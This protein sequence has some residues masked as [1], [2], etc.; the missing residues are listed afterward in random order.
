[1]VVR[2]GARAA[3]ALIALVGTAGRVYFDSVPLPADPS[4]P[5]ASEIFYR[6]GHTV[7]A[8]EDREF[9]QH[10]GISIKGVVRAAW[11]NV[12]G[13]SEGAS[14]ITQQYARNAYLS[15]ERTVARKSREIVL[16][17]KLEDRFTKDQILE[18]YLNAIHFGRGAY[19]IAA[20]AQ[21][22]FGVTVDQLSLAQGA[23]LASVI[24]DPWNFDPTVDPAAAH[25]RWGWIV[26][27]MVEL[28][29]A[30]PD[31]TATLHYPT[32]LPAAP[33]DTTTGGVNGLLVDA[34]ERELA[35]IGVTPQQLHTGGLRIV[36][37]VDATAQREALAA[38]EAGREGL[39]P[40]I[41]AA[42]VAID[43]AT[44][45][46][47]AYY[48]GDR[49][50]GYF[51]DATAPR[52]TGATFAPVTLAAGLVRGY[53]VWSTWDGSSPRTFPDRDGAPVVNADAR[54]CRP[55][56]LVDAVADSVNTPVYALSQVIG[57]PGIRGLALQLGVSPSYDGQ[58]SLVDGPGDARPGRTRADIGLGIY[59]VSPADMASVYATFA[60][61][62]ERM[63]RHVVALVAARTSDQPWYVATPSGTR[64]VSPE[65]AADVTAVLSVAARRHAPANDRPVAG[66]T[67]TQQWG[68]T[69]DNQDAW[70]AGYAPQL[71][72]VVWMGRQVPGPIR[73]RG[74]TPIEGKGRPAGIWTRFMA[75]ALAGQPSLSFPSPGYQGTNVGDVR[76]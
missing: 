48:G 29:W 72:A 41:D 14:T 47:V 10:F 28:G 19:G 57:G 22:Y 12:V 67:G 23:V 74:G 59:P 7:L 8:A 1:V 49:G 2:N 17:V 37:T 24:K 5:Q 64:A 3:L 32:V 15:Q 36:T 73:D 27:S 58:P 13:G 40:A 68:N 50:A 54:Q 34:V 6:D 55:C 9:Y 42:L 53:S 38:V 11:S 75:G 63:P 51:D 31:S 62:G 43:P 45:G 16:A 71:A 4:S 30:P 61:G 44:G 76:P 21:A 33:D 46:V 20:A 69:T 18:R 39:D 65:M 66:K 70:M 25:D 52:R 56:T 26:A 35:G 60:G